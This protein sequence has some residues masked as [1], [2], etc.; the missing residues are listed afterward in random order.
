MYFAYILCSLVWF[1][2]L[3]TAFTHWFLENGRIHSEPNSIFRLHTPADLILFIS[4][5]KAAE[6]LRNLE[7]ESKELLRQQDL[8]KTLENEHID[9]EK[10]IFAT[11]PDCLIAKKKLSKFDLYLS[12]F[13]RLEAKKIKIEDF[14]DYSNDGSLDKDEPL[15]DSEFL[16]SMSS[17]DHLKGVAARRTLTNSSEYGLVNPIPQAKEL[18]KFGHR[19]RNAMLKNTT[20]WV[21]LNFASIYWRIV[22]NSFNAVECLRRALHYSPREHKDL[23]LV[24]LANVLHRSKYSLDAAILMHAALEVTSDFDIVYFT[25]GNIY[26][27]LNQLDLADIC[28]K[29]VSDLQPGFEAARLR[30]HAARCEH[31]MV[32]HFEGVEQKKVEEVIEGLEEVTLKQRIIEDQQ[33]DLLVDRS[34][35]LRKYD[36]NFGQPLEADDNDETTKN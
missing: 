18:S 27:A 22:G 16:F 6:E 33:K 10:I 9:R 20:S 34:S 15:C 7:R 26:G 8:L 17:Y 12:S 21:L 1:P 32:S 13:L 4:Q 36:L 19:I 29:Y 24:S 31:R 30:M 11:D 23:A 14:L 28:F 5:S 35:P 2:L 3:T 25:L